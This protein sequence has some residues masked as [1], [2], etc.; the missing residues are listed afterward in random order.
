METC[1]FG[2]EFVAMKTGVEVLHGIR[3]K[4]HMMGV[5]ID[6]A[7]N[8]YSDS[9]SVTNNT[10]KPKF[11]L[12]KKNN[13]VCYHTVCESVVMGECWWESRWPVII[14]GGKRRYIVNNF[15]HDVYDGEFKPYIVA[16]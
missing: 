16:K 1:T 9:M 4:L 13:T 12:K 6:G 10:S 14:C 8:I 15:L 7:T 11:V 5:P 2:S 3:Y